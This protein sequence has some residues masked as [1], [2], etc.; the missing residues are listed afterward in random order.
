MGGDLN[1][2]ESILLCN[3]LITKIF[4]WDG[5][6][7]FLEKIQGINMPLGGEF[8]LDLQNGIIVVNGVE[9]HVLEEVIYRV[10]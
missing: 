9:I 10:T 1:K 8:T 5:W 7:Q 2:D 3:G 6:L 4:K